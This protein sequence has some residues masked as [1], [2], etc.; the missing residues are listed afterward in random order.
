MYRRIAATLLL[1][2]VLGAGVT[3]CGGDDETGN[4]TDTTATDTNGAD[5]AAGRD[6]FVAQCGSCHTLADAGTSGTIGPVL[7]D[8]GLDEAT[9]EQQVRAGGG[10]MPSFEGTL[11]DEEIANVSAYVAAES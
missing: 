5:A 7:D 1:A 6:V 3:A 4:G 11:S 8:A 2:L 10:A 9:V